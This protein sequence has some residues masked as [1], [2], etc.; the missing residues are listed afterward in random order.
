M[1]DFVRIYYSNKEKFEP[2]VLNP[3]NFETIDAVMEYHSGELKYPYKTKLG[4]MDV[5]ISEKS[6][7]VK[8]SLHKLHN[9]ITIGEDQNHNDFTYSS[10]CKTIDLLSTKIIDVESTRLTQLEFGFNIKVD[11]KPEEII[12]RNV[13]MHRYKGGS[14]NDYRGKGE[15]KQFCRNNYIIKIYDKGKQYQLNDNI[16]RFEIKF[17]KA[18]EFN[19]L[20]IFNISDL[21]SKSVLRKLFVYLIKRLDELTIMDDFDELSIPNKKDYDMLSRYAN[22]NF[23]SEELKG[24]HQQKKARHKKFFYNLLEKNELLKTKA[25]LKKSLYKKF[26]YLIN[27]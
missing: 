27:N 23:W 6:G 17:I 20:G 11:K 12:R 10:F 3:E 16:L 21:K 5:G 1:I 26:I 19:N 4:V 15:L 22:P 9:Y 7:Y 25:F 2:F 24:V 8:N 14:S 13:I 18:V